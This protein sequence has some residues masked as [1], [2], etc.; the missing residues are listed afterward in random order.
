MARPRSCRLQ[1]RAFLVGFLGDGCGSCPTQGCAT[2]RNI[3][4]RRVTI[5]DP[6]LSPGVI[7]GNA[8]NPMAAVVLDD[9]AVRYPSTSLRGRF[10]WGRRF[11]C[12]HA[13]VTTRGKTAKIPSCASGVMGEV[14]AASL[15]DPG[16]PVSVKASR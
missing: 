3:T 13:R 16:E 11:R 14:A 1:G 4:L 7:L 10:P 12:E 15:R 2:F 9:V 6:L 5:D 8:T